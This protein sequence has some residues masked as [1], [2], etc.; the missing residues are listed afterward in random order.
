MSWTIKRDGADAVVEIP[1]CRC[2]KKWH[3]LTDVETRYR[4]RYVDLIVTPKSREIFLKR[5]VLV[6]EMRKFFGCARLHRSGNADDAVH[7]RWSFDGAAFHHSSQ[8]HRK[9]I[10]TC[11]SRLEL[12]L[13]RLVVGG[14]DRV[15]IEINRNFRNEGISA[16]STIREFTMLEFYE[17]YSDYRVFMDLTEELFATLAKAVTGGTAVKYGDHEIDFAKWQRL[18]MREAVSRY[19]SSGGM[20]QRLER[21]RSHYKLLAHRRMAQRQ[22]TR[23][24][25]LT[26]WSAR[27]CA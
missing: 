25:P 7:R 10:C 2:P 24:A 1:C 17:A 6:R 4:Q 18:T 21:A 3:G 5:A 26:R 8:H 22:H 27:G 15:G 13:K 14:L 9:W 23:A 12:Y 20:A 11:A 19:R 16:P